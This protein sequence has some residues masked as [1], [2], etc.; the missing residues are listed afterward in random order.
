[1]YNYYSYGRPI[2]CSICGSP[3]STKTSCPLNPDS[4]NAIPERHTLAFSAGPIL[5]HVPKSPSPVKEVHKSPS[6][7]K[8]VSSDEIFFNSKS[9]NYYKLSNF[10][11]GVEAC[12]M[13]DRFLDVEIQA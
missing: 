5:Y 4:K 13:K 11:G 12:Y 1:M 10:F 8:P 9:K 7:V 3:G 6:P 2:S